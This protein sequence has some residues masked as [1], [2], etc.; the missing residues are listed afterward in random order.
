MYIINSKEQILPE[1][2]TSPQPGKKLPAFYG[3]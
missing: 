1:K 2:L 3:T